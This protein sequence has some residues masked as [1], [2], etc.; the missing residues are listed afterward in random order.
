METMSLWQNL[1]L[2]AWLPPNHPVRP[3]SRDLSLYISTF[4]PF[5]PHGT[6]QVI[7]KILWHS[8]K[9]IIFLPVWQ[10]RYDFDSFTPDSFCCVL[11]VVII[12]FIWQSRERR[13]VPLS[14]QSGIACLKN[15]CSTLVKKS[16][17]CYILPPLTSK[18]WVSTSGC[19]ICLCVNLV[20]CRYII[21]IYHHRI[22][23]H[24]NHDGKQQ[25]RSMLDTCS[26]LN[27]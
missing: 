18:F 7:T 1:H 26:N 14:K 3:N 17:L 2:L 20:Q 21:C 5:P 15:S 8:K 23:S 24:A 9:Y 25:E 10:K 19:L 22:L 12:F 13:S 6:H 16:L 4:Q 27:N 11:A